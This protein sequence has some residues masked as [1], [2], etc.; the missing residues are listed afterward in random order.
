M[1]ADAI[2]GVWTFSIA[3]ARGLAERGVGVVLATTGPRPTPAQRKEALAI[4][5]L[6]LEQSD[7]ALEWMDWPWADMTAAGD[8]LLDLDRRHDPDVVH[9]S[10]FGH[11]VLPFRAP[12]V[13]TAHACA[14]SW[15]RA[16]YRAR[17]PALYDRY[18]EI[19]RVGL[20]AAA[21]VVAPTIAAY[22]MLEVEHGDH[23]TVYAVPHG[24]DS[25]G[26]LAE[27][28]LPFFLAA[29]R[30]WDEAKNARLLERAA[31]EL[32]WPLRIA[33]D[34]EVPPSAGS[35]IA[36]LGV[37]ER[38]HLLRWT[39]SAAIFVHP[40]KYEPFGMT[41]LEAALSGCALLLADLPSLREVWQGAALYFSP[42]SPE[43]LIAK[44]N[45]L[46]EQAGLRRSM[47]GRALDRAR[48]FSIEQMVS[49]YLGVYREALAVSEP[50]YR[51]R[52]PSPTA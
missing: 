42:D 6:V 50:S 32:G 43:D 18:R 24:L 30:R 17:P 38:S 5:G 49:A 22:D 33:G 4:P 9:L 21:V 51:P 26:P 10:S 44:A 27:P 40:A 46:V 23:P 48:R 8:W 47:S 36:W 15:W 2:G 7:F 52:A 1:T 13:I 28:K 11:A 19:V 45:A 3:L 34:H 25:D 14:C 12:V 20:D 31:G 41:V 39:R 35:K 37:L 16:V 29:A